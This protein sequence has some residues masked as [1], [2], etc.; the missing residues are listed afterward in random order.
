MGRMVYRLLE[1]GR[2]ILQDVTGYLPGA[3]F[4]RT[5]R[6]F[7]AAHGDRVAESAYW[8][9]DYDGLD[10]R[11]IS[12]AH[13]GDIVTVTAPRF[14]PEHVIGVLAPSDLVYGMTRMWELLSDDDTGQICVE[15][16]RTTLM[17]WFEARLGGPVDVGDGEV[18]LEVTHDGD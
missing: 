7:M 17:A 8:C 4:A 2:G 12:G 5:H 13:V 6:A 11:D 15:R 3:T 18:L 16:D 10:A 1:D 9:S 14:S